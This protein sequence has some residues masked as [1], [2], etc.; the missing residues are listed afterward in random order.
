MRYLI[1]GLGNIGDGYTMTRHNA[2]FI[3]LDELAKDFGVSFTSGRYALWA[4]ARY[5]SRTI[6]MIKPSTYMNLSGKALKY[7]LDAEKIP[8]E[9]LLVIHDDIDLQ[10]GAI[11]IR[12]NGSGGPH[13]GMNDIIYRLTSEDFPRLRFGIGNDFARGFQSEYVLGRWSPEEEKLL[14]ERIPFA[15]NAIK[16][17]I[18]SGIEHTRNLYNNK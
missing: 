8:L 15:V 5:K 11:R 7:W 18:G 6:I 10:P 17:F 9:N 3:I 16:S 1:A 13:N 14:T 2:G 4:T 12:K